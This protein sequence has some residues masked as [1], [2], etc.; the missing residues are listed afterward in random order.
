MRVERHQEG[1]LGAGSGGS[2]AGT[3][4]NLLSLL[5]AEEKLKK[6]LVIVLSLGVGV[7]GAEKDRELLL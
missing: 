2:Q 3:D 7:K 5:R 4:E 1:L 6:L